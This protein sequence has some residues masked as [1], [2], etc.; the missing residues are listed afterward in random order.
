MKNYLRSFSSRGAKVL[1]SII[2][3]VLVC[4]GLA[5]TCFG[6]ETSPSPGKSFI[7]Y[8]LSM[9]I[10][11]PLSK[12]AWGVPTVGLRDTSNGLEDGTMKMWNYWDGQIIKGPDGKYHIFAS[13][14]NQ[15]EGHRAWASSRAVH[16]VSDSLYGPYIDKGVCWPDDES[17][18]GHNVSALVL[19]DG[20]YAIIVSA[21]RPGTVYVSDSL[22]GPWKKLGEF[23]H[24]GGSSSWSNASMMVRPDG[25]FEIVDRNNVYI[26]KTGVLGP[27]ISYG[28]YKKA[29]GLPLETL[30][31]PVIWYSGGLYHIVVNGWRPRKAYHI[32]SVDGINNWKFQGLAYDPTRDFLRYTDGTVN[33][34][35]KLERPNVYIENGHV[36]AVTLAAIDVPKS[37]NKG[38]DNHGSKILVIPFDGAAL[39]RD[40]QSGITHSPTPP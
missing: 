26:S 38:N 14:W 36:V 7:D 16:A 27:Y 8:F 1:G 37:V 29:E 39:D 5:D 21:T 9:P 11:K 19:P 12:D 4:L 34:W 30:E 33:H 15:A 24:K 28:T 13:R 25:G 32:T 3:A 17:G 10:I 18:K 31:D 35:N 6:Q 2:S 40:M 22:D 20:R 23:T